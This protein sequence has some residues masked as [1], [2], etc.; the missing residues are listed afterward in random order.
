MAGVLRG[1]GID[2][3]LE[4]PCDA[5]VRVAVASSTSA[6]LPAQSAQQ[7]SLLILSDIR[8]M[9]EGLAEVL[10]RDDG[11]QTITVAADP[12]EAIAVM[13]TAMPDL[14]LIDVALPD[15]LAAVGRLHRVAPRIRIVALAVAETEA[16]IIAWA[17]AGACGYVPRS[18]ALAD[19]I[20][21]L[22]NIMRGEQTCSTRV[23]AGLM[24]WIADGPRIDKAAARARPALT[25]REEEIASLIAAGLSNK[26][27]ARR[28]KICV[29]TTKSHVHNILAKLELE[30]RGQVSRW[31]RENP[32]A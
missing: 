15:G 18:A 16:E 32:P 13:R 30:R 28:L 27:I 17:A 1:N 23:A 3:A 24:R 9:R 10:G 25:A 31:L 22:S 5:A 4:K 11:F 21:F 19:L 7:L 14:V 20:G 8:F 6:E 29:P 12:G 2:R 26:E